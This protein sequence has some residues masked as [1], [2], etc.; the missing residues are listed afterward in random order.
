MGDTD[1]DCEAVAHRDDDTVPDSDSDGVSVADWESVL[2]RDV[3]SVREVV[4]DGVCESEDDSDGETEA[5]TDCV[6]DTV[7]D[8]ELESVCDGHCE[9]VLEVVPDIEVLKDD[10]RLPVPVSD[11]MDGDGDGVDP[12]GAQNGPMLNVAR[13][14]PSM[15][16]SGDAD[17][18]DGDDVADDW[19][20]TTCARVGAEGSTQGER[21]R[22]RGEGCRA[23]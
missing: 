15:D 5:V 11:A 20:V 2:V 8:S 7:C 4:G 19:T 22:E 17:A 23:L 10:V 18:M 12:A 9:D 16:A 21:G 3:L 14:V 13:C 1:G 6:R